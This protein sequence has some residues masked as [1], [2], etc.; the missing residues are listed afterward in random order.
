MAAMPRNHRLSHLKAVFPWPALVLAGCTVLPHAPATVPPSLDAGPRTVIYVVKR[1][2]HTDIGFDAADVAAPLAT[3]H[4][5]LPTAH[6][7]LFGF[8]DRHYLVTR[9]RSVSGLLGA[10]W[11]GP[12]VVLVTGL[13]TTPERAFGDKEVRRL[14]LSA[15]QSRQLQQY[16]WNS[17]M[18]TDGAAQVLAPGPYD[19]SVYYASSIRY[20]GLNTCN[21][22]TAAAL[23]TAGLPVHSSGVEFSG[24][25]WRQIG[26][27]QRLEQAATSNLPRPD[28]SAHSDA[29]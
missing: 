29:Q 13:T 2:W 18:A 14:T 1:R 21:T 19:G 9:N 23:E 3:V 12:G 16:V 20:S 10:L 27:L 25:V 24:Q 5:D 26:A 6:F 7:L 15:A 28:A 11:A 8:G 17:L 4:S 22:W